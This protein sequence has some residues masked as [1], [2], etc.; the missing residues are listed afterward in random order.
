M[1]PGQRDGPA[2]FQGT[3]KSE[4]TQ[5][6]HNPSLLCVP[7]RDLGALCANAPRA[8]CANVPHTPGL[9][10]PMAVAIFP[11]GVWFVSRCWSFVPMPIY[12]FRC[13]PCVKDFEELVRS[14]TEAIPCPDCGSEGG[15]HRLAS[16]CAISTGG[17]TSTAPSS[18]GHG[19][20]CGSCSGGSCGSCGCH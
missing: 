20:G 4:A 16:A 5:P 1:R 18:S 11:P 9:R 6:D 10:R 15:V 13:E 8:L 17:H 12:E 14:G 2:C 3:G 7:L 19:G